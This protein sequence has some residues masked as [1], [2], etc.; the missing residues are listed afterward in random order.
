MKKLAV[1]GCSFMWSSKPGYDSIS[2]DSWPPFLD[3]DFFPDTIK[4]E[5]KER[6][7]EH[8]PSFIDIYAHEKNLK[9]SYF[10]EGGSSN[11]G[12]R[13]QID[14]AIEVRPD[15]VVI[16]ATDPGRF[17]IAIDDFNFFYSTAHIK[18]PEIRLAVKHYTM[19]RNEKLFASKSYFF[20]Q[21]GLEK[22]QRLNIPFLFIP[23]PMR[24]HNWDDYDK[25][26]PSD[27]LQP[28]DLAKTSSLGGN[29]MTKQNIVD[30]SNIMLDITQDW[31]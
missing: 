20:L 14:K 7:Y 25:L 11:F 15:F 3:F 9:V 10:S 8:W 30:L 21:S 18:N 29:H 31:N 6:K 17:E 13:T 28:W 5:L 2:T 16:G 4:V 22:L 24:H 19:I 12:I 27:K 26:W 1:C 23:G